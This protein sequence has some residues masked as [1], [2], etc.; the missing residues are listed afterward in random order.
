MST[1]PSLPP[2]LV[3]AGTVALGL[4]LIFHVVY[5]AIVPSYNQPTLSLAFLGAFCAALGVQK[6]LRGG[7][8][9]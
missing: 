6:A 4:L 7:G 9:S 2:W 8:D 1:T 5:D 3:Q